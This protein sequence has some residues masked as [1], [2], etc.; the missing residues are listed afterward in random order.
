MLMLACGRVGVD[1]I[2]AERAMGFQFA[3]KLLSHSQRL[4]IINIFN[5]DLKLD[6][7]MA[8]SA[9]TKQHVPFYVLHKTYFP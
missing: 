6:F 9:K 7:K 3:H 4:T 5:H 8:H 1:Q 2:T